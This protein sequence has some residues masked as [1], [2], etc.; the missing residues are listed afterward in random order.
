MLLIKNYPHNIY[1]KVIYL[2]ILS[3][4][5]FT[6]DGVGRDGAICYT[7]DIIKVTI[8]NKINADPSIHPKKLLYII[9]I[10]TIIYLTKY[11]I[12]LP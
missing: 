2:Y 6:D 10:L 12:N 3:G 7:Y 8:L 1:S 11:I 4:A 5:A 9:H